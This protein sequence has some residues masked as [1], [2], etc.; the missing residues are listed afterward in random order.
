MPFRTYCQKHPVLHTTQL[1][2]LTVRQHRDMEQSFAAGDMAAFTSSAL[3]H[4]YLFKEISKDPSIS[5]NSLPFWP[6]LFNL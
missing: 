1:E 4:K 6:P 5:N 2:L 3:R